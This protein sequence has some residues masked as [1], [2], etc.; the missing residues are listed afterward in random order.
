MGAIEGTGVGFGDGLPAST[1]GG[2][3][4]GLADGAGVGTDVVGCGVGGGTGAGVGA[5]TGRAGST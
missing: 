5:E 4:V 3:V 1:V 2:G